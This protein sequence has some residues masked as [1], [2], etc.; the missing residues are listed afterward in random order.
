MQIGQL[1]VRPDAPA[2]EKFLLPDVLHGH[3]QCYDLSLGPHSTWAIGEGTFV[4][5][6][7]NELGDFEKAAEYHSRTGRD[8]FVWWEALQ[9]K[10]PK[11][12]WKSENDRICSVDECWGHLKLSAGSVFCKKCPRGYH[13]S[14]ISIPVVGDAFECAVLGWKCTARTTPILK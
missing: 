6:E 8:V 14:C 9:S 12:G 7:G 5:F 10:P 13:L 2:A 11:Q 1:S 4:D 3:A